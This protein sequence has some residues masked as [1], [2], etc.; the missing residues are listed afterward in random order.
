MRT[1]FVLLVVGLGV[2][3]GQESRPESRPDSPLARIEAI[4]QLVTDAVRENPGDALRASLSETLLAAAPWQRIRAHL[5]ATAKIHGRG[6][7]YSWGS[8]GPKAR[9]GSFWIALEKGSEMWCDVVLDPDGRTLSGLL[10][11]DPHR[12]G[13]SV[14]DVLKDFAKFPGT[15]AA[16]IGTLGDDVDLVA[17]HAPE[18][19][20]PTGST[21][22]LWVLG[23]LAAGV[24]DGSR[25]WDETTTLTKARMSAPSGRLHQWPEG[26]P[27]TLAALAGAMI[28]E[29]DNTATDHLLFHLGRTTVESWMRKTGHATPAANVPLLATRELF[30]LKFSADASR[31]DRWMTATPEGRRALL[32]SF[33]GLSMDDV[34]S[35]A[36]PVR[37]RDIE[38]F[39]S[40]L[41]LLRTMNGLRKIDDGG[42]AVSLLGINPAF[43]V[44]SSR[45]PI[46]AYKG[47]SEPGV[48]NMT[49][50]W[51]DDRGRWMA[52]AFSWC[53]DDAVVDETRL[54]RL[55]TRAIH[56]ARRLP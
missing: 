13:Q 25:R 43:R 32:A 42:R 6:I 46:V 49:W 34:A 40:P 50:M 26:T 5:V 15:T 45:F 56:A 1:L 24:E 19:P 44:D 20:L 30:L 11:Q 8:G 55:A 2:T 39:A 16:A 36:L 18:L 35:P 23:A 54:L 48:L 37:P 33:A 17:A 51:K 9:S 3:V 41:D 27:F 10:F 4:A 22:K 14:D 7:G 47:G 53:R 52:A 12:I 31:I 29:S 38:W 28:S 21:F